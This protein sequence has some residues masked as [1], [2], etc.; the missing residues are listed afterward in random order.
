M[1]GAYDLASPNPFTFQMRQEGDTIEVIYERIDPSLRAQIAAFPDFSG[2]S[3]YVTG[4][5]HAYPDVPSR[6]YLVAD[7]IELISQ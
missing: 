1:K 6:F 7:K 3:F 5:V 4:T 2:I